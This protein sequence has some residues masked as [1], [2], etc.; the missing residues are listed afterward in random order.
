MTKLNL[1][2]TSM[3]ALS[4]DEAL[5]KHLNVAVDTVMASVESGLG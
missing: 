4:D 3:A 2:T 5:N 1:K